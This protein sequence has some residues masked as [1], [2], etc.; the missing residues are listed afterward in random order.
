VNKVALFPVILELL[1]IEGCFPIHLA[2]PAT[3][4]LLDVI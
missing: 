2:P 4:A 1:S 3:V